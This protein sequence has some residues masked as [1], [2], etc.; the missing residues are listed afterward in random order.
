[1]ESGEGIE[2]N[3]AKPLADAPRH[4]VESGEG[5]ERL[6]TLFNYMIG[7]RP[8]E[9]GEGIERIKPKRYGQKLLFRMWNPVKELKEASA[10]A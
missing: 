1:M 2:S 9:S 8:V 3:V 6:I 4:E 7:R 10:R 5:I